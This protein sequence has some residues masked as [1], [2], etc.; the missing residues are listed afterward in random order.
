MDTKFIQLNLLSK[1]SSYYGPI[2]FICEISINNQTKIIKY[3]QYTSWA[4]PIPNTIKEIITKYSEIKQLVQLTRMEDLIQFNLRINVWTAKDAHLLTFGQERFRCSFGDIQTLESRQI[5]NELGLSNPDESNCIKVFEQIIKQL[6]SSTSSEYLAIKLFQPN[7][8]LVSNYMYGN[9]LLFDSGSI[10]LNPKLELELYFRITDQIYM[11]DKVDNIQNSLT[12]GS[13]YKITV[14][15]SQIDLSTT[16]LNSGIN[17]SQL[18]NTYIFIPVGKPR[19]EEFDIYIKQMDKLKSSQEYLQADKFL[20]TW[21]QT[22]NLELK[23]YIK[24][25]A[26][27]ISLDINIDNLDLS[28][29]QTLELNDL[30][31]GSESE[32]ESINY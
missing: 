22:E 18:F 21:T 24:E 13:S 17:L 28:E 10:C 32:S 9:K 12:I 7:S 6:E 16:D 19:S 5:K 2:E 30:A 26:D 8:K 23:K 1:T 15:S 11:S 27:Q 3:E 14:G 29:N 20:Q 31:L 25:I 4:D